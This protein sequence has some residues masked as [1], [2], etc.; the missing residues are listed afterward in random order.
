MLTAD[1]VSRSAVPISA[2]NSGMAKPPA[3]TAAGSP[4]TM[5]PNR[6][7]ASRIVNMRS[8]R[9]QNTS[10]ASIHSTSTQMAVA[11][12]SARPTSPSN[13]ARPARRARMT[14]RSVS[15]AACSNAQNDNLRCN[16]MNIQPMAGEATAAPI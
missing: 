16:W 8:A 15:N 3:I 14:Q 7:F 2:T 5:R 11:I 13:C 10:P 1:T 9:P 4:A 6:L 12:T